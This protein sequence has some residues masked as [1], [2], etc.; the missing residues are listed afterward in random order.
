[1]TAEK[2]ENSYNILGLGLIFFVLCALA[3]ITYLCQRCGG[4]RTPAIH[5]EE[6]R[7]GVDKTCT[8]EIDS[9]RAAA[10]LRYLSTFTLVSVISYASYV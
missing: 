8:E 3:A 9:M 7:L 5:D 10:I 2:G 4:G 6:E 1:M